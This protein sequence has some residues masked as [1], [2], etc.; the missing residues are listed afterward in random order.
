MKRLCI[1]NIYRSVCAGLGE[2]TSKRGLHGER[3]QR[4]R[5]CPLLYWEV[6]LCLP[7]KLHFRAPA[8]IWSGTGHAIYTMLRKSHHASIGLGTGRF[9]GDGTVLTTEECVAAGCAGLG[10]CS[11]FMFDI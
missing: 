7:S 5:N 6:L 1:S 4:G 9:S 3:K 8:N 10:R 2:S 11:N